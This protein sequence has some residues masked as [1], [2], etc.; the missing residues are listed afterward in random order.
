MPGLDSWLVLG[1]AGVIGLV[2]AGLTWLGYVAF[3]VVETS[4]VGALVVG[5]LYLSWPIGLGV[6]LSGTLFQFSSLAV[7]SGRE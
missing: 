3:V 6:F 4:F 2:M 7:L 5:G 1:V